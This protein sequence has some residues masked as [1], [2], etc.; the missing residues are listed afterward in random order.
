L[1]EH[2]ERLAQHAFRGGEWEKAVKYL[3]QAGAKAAVHSA[4]REAVTC[5]EQALLALEHL[6]ASRPRDEEAIDIRFDLRNALV[7]LGEGQ[8]GQILEHLRAAG[9][10][11]ETLDDQCRLGWVSR[12]M[13]NY[14]WFSG[15]LDSALTSGQ[16]AFA[17]GK[18]LEDVALQVMTNLD[19]GRA[20][21]TLGDYP[22]AIDLLRPNMVLLN[23]ALSHGRFGLTAIPAVG[24]RVWL[25]WC[26]AELGAF[27][28]GIAIAEEGLRLAEAADNPFSLVEA[29]RGISYV[30]LRKGE[31]HSA[32]PALEDALKVCHDWNILLLSPLVASGLSAAYALS[33]RAEEALSLLRQAD[34]WMTPR[35]VGS[36]MGYIWLSEAYLRAGCSAEGT[37]HAMR[38]LALSRER[39]Q[40]GD[41]A[42][43]LYLLG[44]LNAWGDPPEIEPAKHSY[45]QSLALADDLGMRPLQ[46]H[47]HRGLGMLYA[48]VGQ[49]QHARTELSTA[50]ALYRSMDMTFWLPQA[51]AAL[52]QV[53]GR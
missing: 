15:E 43:T 17:L 10:L 47:G 39:K 48:T 3:R 14:F 2:I 8:Y 9:S 25:A 45:R 35:A 51:E 44:E 46:A 29:Y 30:Y 23:D 42:W 11:A 7:P 40:R 33:G 21:Y 16:R 49:Q 6:P 32:V 52:G 34:G 22:R 36:S 5:F 53:E 18:T 4:H 28:E 37:A 31:F 38:G 50:I 24:S 13:T 1:V 12:Y 41:E 19:L 20:Y 26:L 27:T